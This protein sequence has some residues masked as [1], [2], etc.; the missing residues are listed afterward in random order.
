MHYF[1]ELL[2][3][4]VIVD[5]RQVVVDLDVLYA[6]ARQLVVYLALHLANQF[7]NNP[8]PNALTVLLLVVLHLRLRIHLVDQDV[9]QAV[10]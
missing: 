10:R 4:A 7:Y 9:E 3:K 5:R 2:E 1:A 6:E 8:S